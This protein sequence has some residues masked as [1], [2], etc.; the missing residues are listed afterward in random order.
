MMTEAGIQAGVFADTY[1]S[2]GEPLGGDAWAVRLHRKPLVRFVWIG[3][4]LMGLGGSLAVLDKRY[5]R[6]RE[7][8]DLARQAANTSTA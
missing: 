7:R 5:R 2:L 4:L 1:I 3:A 6:L 8:R